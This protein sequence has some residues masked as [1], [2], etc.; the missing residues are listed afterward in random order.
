MQIAGAVASRRLVT[1]KLNGPAEEAGLHPHFTRAR[2]SRAVA[3]ELDA[4]FKTEGLTSSSII[5]NLRLLRRSVGLQFPC[6]RK[7]SLRQGQLTPSSLRRRRN[8]R[9]VGTKSEL[10]RAQLV[11]RLFMSKGKKK[12]APDCNFSLSHRSLFSG[13]PHRRD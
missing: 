7:K 9:R 4:R 10:N 3:C 13:V 5:R 6:E 11:S 8:R 2:K 1:E 12:K